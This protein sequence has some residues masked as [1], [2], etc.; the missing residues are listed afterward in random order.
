MKW[1]LRLQELV[2][3]GG[4][5]AAAGCGGFMPGGKCNANPDPCCF[6]SKSAACAEYTAC[7]AIGGQI[8][9]SGCVTPD[10]GSPDLASVVDFDVDASHD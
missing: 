2:L 1:R 6:D 9:A 7:E 5:L 4:S 10:A 8:E 3:A